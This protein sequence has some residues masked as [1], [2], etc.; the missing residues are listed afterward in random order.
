MLII[1]LCVLSTVASHEAGYTFRWLMVLKVVYI[2]M[3]AKTVTCEGYR[4]AWRL[5]K[6]KYVLKR[7][8]LPSQT[9]PVPGLCCFVSGVT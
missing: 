1:V 8:N 3:A 2:A 7:V 6:R 4:V 9:H 5:Y